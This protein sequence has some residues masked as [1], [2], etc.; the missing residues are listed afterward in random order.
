MTKVWTKLIRLIQKATDGKAD[1]L[2]DAWIST[3]SPLDDALASR[4]IEK[5]AKALKDC[6]PIIKQIIPHVKNNGLKELGSMRVKAL[7]DTVWKLEYEDGDIN[8]VNRFF[9]ETYF[10]VSNLLSL[11]FK[12]AI[13]AFG[14]AVDAFGNAFGDVTETFGKAIGYTAKG[15][16]DL[17]GNTVKG[18]GGIV[19]GIFG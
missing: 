3:L 14:N 10:P 6:V 16:G 18:F 7:E 4:D 19:N 8:D 11:M 12:I 13:D 1:A 5:I 9:L 17:V 15:F 2:F